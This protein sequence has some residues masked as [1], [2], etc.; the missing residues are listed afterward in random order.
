MK[1]QNTCSKYFRTLGKR[2][3]LRVYVHIFLHDC[4]IF[5]VRKLQEIK[6]SPPYCSSQKILHLLKAPD[7]MYLKLSAI[8]TNMF[9][10]EKHRSPSFSS[11]NCCTCDAGSSKLENFPRKGPR[12]S[13]DFTWTI[14]DFSSGFYM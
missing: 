13:W 5:V 12:R 6:T 8:S 4:S 14:F 10:E 2:R 3:R 7:K 9:H 1:T 11:S